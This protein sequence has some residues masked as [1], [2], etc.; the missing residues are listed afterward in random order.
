M[1]VTADNAVDAAHA[2]RCPLPFES[3]M[4]DGCMARGLAVEEG[5]A[6]HNFTGPQ[7]FG[8]ANMTD[9]L[10]AVRELV[11]EKKL[12]TLSEYAEAMNANFGIVEPLPMRVKGGKVARYEVVAARALE[13]IEQIKPLVLEQRSGEE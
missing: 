12:L 3:S 10:L 6:K 5:G 1:M 9:A 11:Y 4:V 7:G 8:I 2:A 13:E